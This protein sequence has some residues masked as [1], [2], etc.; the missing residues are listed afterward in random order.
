MT[1]TAASITSAPR[2]MQPCRQGM[3]R[4]QCRW[5]SQYSYPIGGSWR[6]FKDIY[7]RLPLEAELL[8]NS[9]LPRAY[10]SNPLRRSLRYNFVICWKSVDRHTIIKPYIEDNKLHGVDLNEN[11]QT[12]STKTQPRNH[13]P[14]PPPPR[15]RPPHPPPPP[16]RPA[17]PLAPSG[18]LDHGA[19][20][21]LGRRLPLHD[22]GA[23][24]LRGELRP[25]RGH[26][27]V[28][29]RGRRLGPGPGRSRKS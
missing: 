8:H 6:R 27:R 22:R 16:R 7:Y 25:Q 11:H 1:R 10:R 29:P 19:R 28:V 5:E 2:V 13:A 24:L 14:P 4:D 21:R 3:S 9:T 18:R 15:P 17:S 26:D 12:P 23:G 20:R